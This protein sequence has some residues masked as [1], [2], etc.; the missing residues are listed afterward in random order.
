ASALNAI[1]NPKPHSHSKHSKFCNQ[2]WTK[3]LFYSVLMGGSDC[4]RTVPLQS[5]MDGSDCKR[6]V[7]LQSQ[8]V[9]GWFWLQK[10][11]PFATTNQ[12][13]RPFVTKFGLIGCLGVCWW[14]IFLWGGDET[15]ASDWLSGA[16]ATVKKIVFYCFFKSS[17]SLLQKSKLRVVFH[18]LWDLFCNN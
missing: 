9:D 1:F 13:N 7:P 5:L 14:V 4:K 8:F 15:K 3:R 11:R 10:N 2:N 12:K 18:Q 16:F 6:T 17:V